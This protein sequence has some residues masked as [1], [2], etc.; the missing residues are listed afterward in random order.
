MNDP[1]EFYETKSYAELRQM[2]REQGETR[3]LKR[4]IVRRH[5]ENELTAYFYRW[6]NTES[7]WV[8]GAR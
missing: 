2:V 6:M 7:A 4:A 5:R 3:D 1:Q 8:H